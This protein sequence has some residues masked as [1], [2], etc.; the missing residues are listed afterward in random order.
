METKK[1]GEEVIIKIKERSAKQ[2]KASKEA[3]VNMVVYTCIENHIL[4][5]NNCT[6]PE[7]GLYRRAEQ[8]KSAMEM[9]LNHGL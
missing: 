9:Q 4:L 3:E 6:E 2:L 7:H 1:G 5:S 8:D